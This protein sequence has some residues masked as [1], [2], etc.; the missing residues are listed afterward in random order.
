MKA[1]HQPAHVGAAVGECFALLFDL[2]KLL[3]LVHS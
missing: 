2:I 3:Y 1:S